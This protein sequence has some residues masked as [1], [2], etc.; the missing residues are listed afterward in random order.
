MSRS[1]Q[2]NEQKPIPADQI[3]RLEFFVEGTPISQGSKSATIIGRHAVLYDV[4]AVK[5]KPWRAKVRKGAEDALA[6]R[7][8]FPPQ[9]QVALIVDFYMPRGKTVKRP[10]PSVAPDLD[11]MVRAV[12]DSL[13]DSG[14]LTDDAQIVTIS[15]RKHYADD[16]PGV[17]IVVRELA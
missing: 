15:A 12:G 17:R 1:R 7:A 8:G 3:E 11:K 16:K 10:R 6:G 14:V 13:T 4:N 2:S 5:L 9:Q